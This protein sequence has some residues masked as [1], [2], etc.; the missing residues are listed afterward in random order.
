MVGKGGGYF[1]VG[2]GG[3]G[4]GGG[5]VSWSSVVSWGCSVSYWSGYFSDD[6]GDWMSSWLTVDDSVETV[7]WVSDV[8]DGALGTVSLDEGVA[9]LDDISVT[10]LVLALGVSGQTVL[11]VVGEAV[12]WVWIILFDWG[13]YHSL[14]YWGGVGQRG[15]H[16]GNGGGVSEWSGGV[17]LG[18]V[19]D[20]SGVGHGD[21]GGEQNELKRTTLNQLLAHHHLENRQEIEVVIRY[22]KQIFQ[23]HG[24]SS[25][26]FT[27][28]H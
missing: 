12:L 2:G 23:L 27:A 1:S 18:G 10:L 4:S 8:L 24:P 20:D 16:L 17:T 25:H 5:V 7:V 13:G 3:I 6:W 28:R 9:A 19:V 11:N 14:G 22:L 15:G 21:Q 26:T